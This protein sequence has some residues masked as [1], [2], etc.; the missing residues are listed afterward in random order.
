MSEM[1]RSARL[2]LTDEEPLDPLR[3]IVD[4]HHHL[5]PE[6]DAR[7][8]GPEYL[9][10]DLL[11]DVQ[12]GHK[13]MET[14]F[15]E[16]GASYHTTDREQLRPAGETEF[17]RAQADACEGSG[18]RIAAIVGYADLALGD[19][20]AEVLHAHDVAGRGLFRG[21]R[22]V[23]AADAFRKGPRT[24][25]LLGQESVRKG[26][27]CLGESGYSFD[28][29]VF[30]HQLTELADAARAVPDTTIVVDHLGVPLNSGPYFEQPEV[31]MIWQQGLR[32]LATCPN[33]MVKLGG[34]G[35]DSLF[36]TDWSARE[37]PPGSDEVSKRWSDA[38]CACIDI[39]GPSRCM[40]ESNYPLDKQAMSYTVLWNAFQKIA[41][42]Y[43]DAEQ[44]ELFATTARRVYRI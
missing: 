7:K 15:I 1:S 37:R 6:V 27:A 28:A 39:V 11:L 33:V 36:G 19:A 41:R 4:A 34:I 23:T 38:I 24:P 20:V 29:F 31:K 14:V 21:V 16:C 13:V 32:A 35:M 9:V 18:V 3:E 22:Y 42:R 44:S 30:H 26:L 43:S 25:G 8:G 2:A 17:A 5:W 40:F 12:S 10:G